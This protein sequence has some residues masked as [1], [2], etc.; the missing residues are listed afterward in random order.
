M[1]HGEIKFLHGDGIHARP[2]MITSRRLEGRLMK[3]SKWNGAMARK[4]G[5]E[6]VAKGS[7]R[8]ERSGCIGE[9]RVRYRRC[10]LDIHMQLMNVRHR[11]SVQHALKVARKTKM[12]DRHQHLAQASLDFE[13]VQ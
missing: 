5:M 7:C 6:P 10:R 9:L 1:Q 12:Y 3:L 2:I 8:R 13:I 11:K 4:I